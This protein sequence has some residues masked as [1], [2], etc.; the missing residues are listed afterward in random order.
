MPD[1]LLNAPEVDG[2]HSYLSGAGISA[3]AIECVDGGT[4]EDVTVDGVDVSG[5]KV[6]IFVR[7]GTRSNRTCAIPPGT[8]H[9]LRRI[10]ISNVRGRAESKMPSSIT[11]VAGCRPTD[12]LLQNI[13]IECIGED[14]DTREI[15]EPDSSLDGKYP[16]ATM[17]SHL[18]LPVYGLYVAS[19]DGVIYDNVLF[20]LR[21]GTTDAR[22]PR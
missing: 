6:P 22:K 4:V 3:I 11:G 13:A 15:S 9:A 12:I 21:I 10:I 8:A 18:R 2:V 19:A 1:D 20:T 14:S 16:E 5:F 17:F 7:G